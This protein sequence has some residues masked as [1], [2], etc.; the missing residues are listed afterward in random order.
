MNCFDTYEDRVDLIH[1]YF[2]K[3]NHDVTVVQSNYRHFK[4]VKRAE[5]KNGFIFIDTD[6][7]MKNLSFN[8]MKS[9]YYFAKNAF[10]IVD[11][12]KPDL[13][14]VLIPPNSLT[15]FAG[16]YKKRNKNV[17][18]IFDLIDLWPETMPIGNIKNVFPFNLWGSIRNENLKYADLIL[19][20][21]DLYQEVLRKHLKGLNLK[22]LY[23]AQHSSTI[24]STP[25]LR[26]DMLEVAYLGSINNIIDIQKIK[27]IIYNLNKLKPVILHIIGDGEKRLELIKEIEDTGAQ[28]R[29][30]GKV[31][32]EKVKQDIFDQCHYALNIMKDTVCVGL[33]MKSIDYA[34][35]GVPLINNIKADTCKL[36]D[37]YEVGVNLNLK[38]EIISL[39]KKITS[40]S[41]EQNINM[42]NNM[43]LLFDE[44]F[45][46]TAFN[47][48]LNS[49]ICESDL[50]E[51]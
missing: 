5:D 46:I 26:A 27:E 21:C 36:V 40:T 1:D 34:K 17:K 31:Y 30:H 39:A 47:M 3:K 15:K 20:E 37:Q 24:K 13:L 2:K 18:L 44:Q 42:R 33:T 51:E 8:R 10:N 16:D 22:T 11:E 7:Y 4:K 14:Y 35:H 48:K 9:H 45:S 43:K 12:I 6:P 28:V 29:F 32:E 19:T 49:I 23:L 41:T 38:T 25:N 50:D